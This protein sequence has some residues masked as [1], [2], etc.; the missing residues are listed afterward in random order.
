MAQA[1]IKKRKR[2]GDSTAKPKKKV[3]INASPEV[4]AVSSVLRPKFCPPVIATAPGFQIPTGISFQ[5]YAPRNDAKSKSKQPKSAGEKDFL[6]HST[7]HRSL[8]YTVKDEAPRGTKP[9]LNHFVGIYD[10]KTGKLEVVE[11]KKMVIRGTVRA[12]QAPETAAGGRNAQQ[13]MMELRTDLGQTFGTK[14]ARKVIQ[15]KVLNAI[16]PQRKIGDL[17]TKIDAAARAMLETVGEVTS[18]MASREELQ[19]VV[20]DAKP[21]PVANVNATEIQDVYDPKKIIGADI[22]NLVPIREWQEK[23]RHNESI[24]IPS[25]FVAARVNALASND[26]TEVV[27]RLRVLRY[28]AFVLLFYL[29]SKPGRVRGTRSLPSREKLRDVLAP[30]PEAVIEN[31]RRKFSDAGQMRKFHIDL[32]VTHCCAFACIVDNFEVDTQNLRDDLKLDQ[33]A[34]NQYFHEIGG[35]V[36]PVVNRELKTTVQLARLTL[37]LN[38]PKQRHIAPKRR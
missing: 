1:S 38:F 31:I 6:L 11:A 13:T 28:F 22:L 12:K 37:P 34:M 18:T 36:K 23:A 29:N 26:D 35:R 15:E 4:A 8:D 10:P 32:L 25:R 3:A 27:T 33:K 19:A 16:A 7:A 21:V 9:A 5:S 14:K 2:D 20:D 17:P 30:A 24:Q